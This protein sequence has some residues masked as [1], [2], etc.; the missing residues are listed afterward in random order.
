MLKYIYTKVHFTILCIHIVYFQIADIHILQRV[1]QVLHVV[2]F[3]RWLHSKKCL[4]KVPPDSLS[5]VKLLILWWITPVEVMRAC[6]EGLGHLYVI[7]PSFSDHTPLLCRSLL[8]SWPSQALW[9]W[10]TLMVSTATRSS[11]LLLLWPLPRCQRS[12]R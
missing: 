7:H 6:C 4:S 11:A 8:L 12:I 10:P 2:L 9:W 5:L 3:V 1:F